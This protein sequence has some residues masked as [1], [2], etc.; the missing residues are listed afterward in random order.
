LNL[1]QQPQVDLLEER[2]FEIDRTRWLIGAQPTWNA[3]A[4][5]LIYRL[6]WHRP[7]RPPVETDG[8]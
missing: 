1:R 8:R 3:L 2:R 6:R 4:A 7:A 5:V